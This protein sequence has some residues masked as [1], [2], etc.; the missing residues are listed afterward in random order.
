MRMH[1][2][3]EHGV[4]EDNRKLEG[5]KAWDTKV[6]I[7]VHV[8]CSQVLKDHDRSHNDDSERLGSGLDPRTRTREVLV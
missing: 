4:L 6:E 3:R 7:V 5:A 8:W 2:M 1:R